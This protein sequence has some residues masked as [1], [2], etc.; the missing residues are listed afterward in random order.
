MTFHAS[1]TAP[2]CVGSLG[3]LIVSV[4]AAC[5]GEPSA[6]NAPG[7]DDATLVEE[8]GD[9]GAGS[10]QDGNTAGDDTRPPAGDSLSG[11]DILVDRDVPPTQVTIGPAGGTVAFEGVE[12]DIPPGALAEE[13]PVRIAF[14]ASTDVPGYTPYSPIYAFEPA[15]TSLAVPATLRA[16]FQGDTARAT[17]FW[18]RAG[19]GGFERLGGTLTTDGRLEASIEH[20]SEGFVADGVQYTDPGDR[21]CVLTRLLEGRSASSAGINGGLALFFTVDDCY[22][23]PITGLDADDFTLLE[24]GR[25]LSSEAQATILPQAGRG[26]FITLTL[27][28]SS[29]T[30]PVVADLLDAAK[31]FLDTVEAARLPAQIQILAFGGEATATER[32]RHT[33]DLAAARSALTDLATWRPADTGATNLHGAVVQA[34]DASAVAQ[35]SY[36]ERNYGGAFSTGYVVVFTDGRDT[37][38]RVQLAEVQAAVAASPDEVFVV[39]LQGR[40]YDEAALTAFA[41]PRN[42]FRA[43]SAAQLGREFGALANRIAGQATRTYLLGYCSPKRAGSHEVSVQVVGAENREQ[44]RYDFPADGFDGTCRASAFTRVCAD[45][46]CGGLGCG[47]CDDRT[48]ACTAVDGHYQCKELCLLLDECSGASLQTELG[49]ELVCEESLTRTDCAEGCLDT[50]SDVNRCGGCDV[51]CPSGAGCQ[52]GDCVCPG[53]DGRDCDGV[54]RDLDVDSMNCGS[55]GNRC[56]AGGS[57]ANGTCICPGTDGE[58]CS[59]ACRDLAVDTANCG[60]CGN[61]CA[62][63]GACADGTCSCPGTDGEVCSGACRD[64]A[65]DR[66]NCGACGSRCAT[67]GTCADG[68]CSCPGTDGEVCSGS[69]RDLA[70]DRTNCGACGNRCAT[71]GTCANGSCGCPGTD[72]RDCGGTCRDV[73]VD[74]SNCGSCGVVCSTNATGC[75]NGVCQCRSGWG[76]P[77]CS[78]RA[79]TV[80]FDPVG[81]LAPVPSTK[82]VLLPGTYGALPTSTKVNYDFDGWSTG[83]GS[84]GLRISP[85][86]EVTTASDHTLYARWLGAPVEVTFDAQGGTPADPATMTVRPGAE[87]GQLPVTSRP[88]YDFTGWYTAIS[89]GL[90]VRDS[91]IVTNERAHAL[92]ARWRVKTFSVHYSVEGGVPCSGAASKDVTFGLPYGAPA[93]STSR[94]G[95]TFA[96]WWT[97]TASSATEVDATTVVTATSGHTIH[98]RWTPNSY[99]VTYHVNGGTTCVGASTQTVSFGVV[100]GPAPCVTTLRGYVLLGWWTATTGGTQISPTTT[101]AT[102]GDHTLYARWG[103]P[104]GFVRISPGTF[105]MGS[106]PG[107]VGRATDEA[108]VAV[109]LTRSFWIK[110][111]EVTESEW[112]TFG[113]IPS[114]Y[115]RRGATFPMGVISWWSALAYA[116]AMSESEGLPPCYTLPQTNPSGTAFCTGRWVRG[117]LDCG[118]QM[119]TVNGGNVYACQGYRLPTEA[120]WEYAARAGTTTATYGGNLSGTSACVTL[121]GA[122]SF[123]SGTPLADLGWY[124]CNYGGMIKA[125]KGRAPNAWGLH[126][127]LGNLWELTWGRYD[128]THTGGTDPQRTASGADRVTRGGSGYDGAGRLRAAARRG[129]S[130]GGYTDGLGFRLVRTVP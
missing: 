105:T 104:P 117:D 21:S 14:A 87:Y 99:V 20:F 108:P 25:E 88:G 26:V 83:R 82:Q 106:P 45:N 33:L 91:T 75:A 69:C 81:G 49:Y 123:P 57:C 29:S 84:S 24:D 36:R 53:A 50:S 43:P 64:L 31:R 60:A 118:D 32:L 5:G 2:R 41:Q 17:L 125:V 119:P 37:A 80:T 74:R 59:G 38:E 46:T 47:A 110:E 54:C 109:T 51:R 19:G 116:N 44:A 114:T 52:A 7:D 65:V 97:G 103:P 67:G 120:E 15:G 90:V 71:G 124:T 11:P 70:V 76:G 35:A 48:Q 9:T 79:F 78:Q 86:V 112:D 127:V 39:G 92:F 89:G 27:D 3:W 34:L 4:L 98:A 94:S 40:D 10:P 23:N 111:T 30:E 101:V 96:G 122:G 12:L 8:V 77:T 72:G 61:R 18:T 73:A 129:I 42:V 68:S 85:E 56:G 130:P 102:A 13:T 93:C 55:C 121:S 22:G 113:A 1:R 62:T 126:D 63:G 16:R 58:V 115:P 28:L 100:Y 6:P 95:Y 66:E 107:E 128:A